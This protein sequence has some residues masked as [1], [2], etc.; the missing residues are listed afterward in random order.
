[1]AQCNGLGLH[2]HGEGWH[3]RV[4]RRASKAQQSSPIGVE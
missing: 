1:M 2:P 3:D 4:G